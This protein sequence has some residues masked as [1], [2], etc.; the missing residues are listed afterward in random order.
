MQILECSDPGG[1]PA[2]LPQDSSTCDGTTVNPN[3][4][5]PGTTG[6]FTD[7]YTLEQLNGGSSPIDCNATNYCV[8]WIGEDYVDTFTG[9]SAQPVAFSPPFLID[10]AGTGGTT[11]T[12]TTEP[13][14]VT[15]GGGPAVTGGA[16]PPTSS[17]TVPA[18]ATT[19]PGATAAG[20][21]TAAGSSASASLDSSASSG[22]SLAF[23]GPP[24]MLPWLVGL[25]L[26]MV[27]GG[28][29]ARRR[30]TRTRP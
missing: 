26:V 21:E 9:S 25:G 7:Q 28:G 20:S 10:A 27:V 13:V 15:T 14:G 30:L 16:S 19:I 6:G 1:D 17:T 8:L 5:I 11:T 4:V 24:T 29:G 3:T 23:T 22:A 18:T 12:T 2:N